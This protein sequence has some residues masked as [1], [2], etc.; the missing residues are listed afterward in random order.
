MAMM[1]GIHDVFMPDTN[2][3]NDPISKKKLLKKEGQY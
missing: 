2:D 3:S 1:T